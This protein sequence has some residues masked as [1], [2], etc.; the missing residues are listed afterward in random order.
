MTLCNACK[1][2]FDQVRTRRPLL[3]CTFNDILL[4]FFRKV[5]LSFRPIYDAHEQLFW[6]FFED[7]LAVSVRSLRTL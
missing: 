1:I 7:Y 2:N 5:S 4:T 6:P 3:K